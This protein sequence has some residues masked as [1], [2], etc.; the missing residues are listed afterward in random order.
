MLFIKSGMIRSLR[1]ALAAVGKMALSNYLAQT[2]LCNVFFMGFG[3][4][5][6]GRL[7]RYELYIV[8]LAIWILQLIYSP[9]WLKYFRYGP[10]EWLWRNLTYMKMQP[11]RKENRP[12]KRN[13]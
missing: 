6:F 9:F 3:F 7:Q 12:I 2:M 8:V 11:L 5:M 1:N 4:A 10:F 13:Q